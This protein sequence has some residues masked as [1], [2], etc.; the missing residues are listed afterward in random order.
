MP[1]YAVETVRMLADR[2]VLEQVGE[3]Y[4]VVGELGGE[5]DIP[6][7]LHALVAARL[8][9]LPDAERSAACRT[10]PWWG[11][12]SPWPRCA[13]SAAATPTTL[14]PLLRPLTRK[15]VLD[16][17]VDP[18]SPERGQYGFVQAVIR[19]VAYST[20]SK[21]ARRAKHLACARWFEG[22]DDDELAGVVADHYLE[23]YRAEPGAPDAEEVA[24]SARIWL[25]RAGDRAHRSARPSRR[26]GMPCRP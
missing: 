23:A 11:T 21:P 15:E 6:E 3:A 18:R 24:D 5:L 22:L 12:A 19:E 8:D 1:L 10:R 2:G 4:R 26:T 25:I 14:E 9:G 16:Q 20:L 7:T 13:P 17:D